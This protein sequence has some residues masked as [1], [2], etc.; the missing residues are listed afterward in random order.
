MWQH[1]AMWGLPQGWDLDRVRAESGNPGAEVLDPEGRLVVL[2]TGA[3]DYEPI[4]PRTIIRF[5]GVCLVLDDTDWHMGS[6]EEDG[7][8]ICWGSYGADLGAAI[9]AL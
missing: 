6:L 8:I 5:S 9:A 1:E 2:D 3:A 4:M 7:S